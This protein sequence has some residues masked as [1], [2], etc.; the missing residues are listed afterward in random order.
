[1]TGRRKKF[2][3]DFTRIIPNNNAPST[4]FSQLTSILA[5]FHSRKDLLD[6]L[7]L[8]EWADFE[9][10][11]GKL[12]I[13]APPMYFFLDQLD[14]D[15]ANAPFHWLKC[16][17][18]LFSSVFRFI[19][20]DVFGGKLHII[21][22][23]REV[24]Y[25]YILQ[26][27]HGNKYLGDSKIKILR[28]DKKLSK[29]FL[30]K[31]IENLDEKYFLLKSKT[32]NA[33]S[34][35]GVQGVHL[36]RQGGKLEDIRTYILRH[37]ML[38]P[39]EIINIGNIFCDEQNN[40]ESADEFEDIIK[41]TVS[42][43]AKSIANDQLS[44]ASI[45]ICNKWI[46]NGAVED[47]NLKF[48]DSNNM[49]K[50]IYNCLCELI[51]YID[52]DRFDADELLFAFSERK[53]FGFNDEDDPLNALFRVGLLGYVELDPD[54]KE[55]AVFFSESRNARFILPLHFKKYVF[56]SCLIDWLGI[57]PIGDPVNA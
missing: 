35:F 48:Y 29:H 18:G 13:K 39:R 14:D 25:S 12:L 6:F 2:L 36:S 31:K 38:L 11:I 33:E 32:K 15:F 5:K 27:Q 17:Y 8:D 55:R 44:M 30:D 34:F 37:T 47:G 56:H 40:I 50:P 19:R 16:Q 20:N 52:K 45:L 24:V 21:V 57:Q 42:T 9:Y 28:W 3:N 43:V 26:T 4:P 51:Q 49:I 54:G 23:I 7:Y 41:K 1:V 10:E 53:T 22:S 46:Y